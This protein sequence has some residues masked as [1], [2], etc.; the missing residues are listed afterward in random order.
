M[1]Y[2]PSFTLSEKTL[3]LV[4]EIMEIVTKL[5]MIEVEGINPKL[6][7][8]NRI[9]T[10]HA[11]LA[12]EN[13]S[14][15]L[16]QVTAILNGKRILGPGQ[17][18]KEVQNAYE[19][20]ELL[21]DLDPFDV[22]SMLKAHRILMNNLTKEAGIFRSGGV[23]IFAG[24][25][26]IH[27]A[28]PASFVSEQIS[29]LLLW[30]KNSELHPLIKSCVFHYE[31]E[32]IHPFADGN[33]RMGRM[34]QTLILYKWKNLF[35]WLPVESLVKDRQD[36]YYKVLGECDKAADSVKFIEFM[37][38]SIRD[39]LVEI[40]STEQVGV[41]VSEQV[42]ILLSA[43]GKDTVSGKELMERVGLK[44]RPTF[45]KNYL[46]PAIENGYL[47]MTIPDKPNSSKQKYRKS[48]I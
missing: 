37:L 15:S 6:R 17:D 13:N 29:Q 43:I 12:I 33:G 10:I 39:S 47:E 38:E 8:N 40:S 34:W 20:Y 27:M 44:H 24:E 41:Q 11:S 36:N 19:A 4:A 28:P 42:E 35:G 5:T 46:L 1:N 23:G 26:L 3:N 45:R 25:N 31:F 18:I 30:V 48:K 9:K 32:F 21:L 2:K 14:L 22:S 16:D 7:R